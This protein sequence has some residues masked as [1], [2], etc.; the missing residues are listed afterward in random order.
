[1]IACLAVP[2]FAAAVERRGQTALAQTPLVI[3]GQPWEAAPLF[4]FSLEAAHQGVR[5]GMPL[6]QAHLLSPEA[7]FL[8]SAPLHYA[9]AD[10]EVTGVLADF[11]HLIAPEALWQ[12]APGV[13]FLPAGARSLPARYT[14]D[15]EALP[16]PEAVF[17]IR[18]MGQAVRDHTR[19]EP[20][21]GLSADP[22][23]AQVAAALARPGSLRPV[24]PGGERAFLAARPLDFLPLERE[25]LRRLRLLGIRTL[26]Q[27]AALSPAALRE[28][29]GTGI[30]PLHRL[31]RGEGAASVAS[32]PPSAQEQAARRFDPPLVNWLD[33]QRLLAEL[34]A[35][36]AGRLAA[37]ALLGGVLHLRVET[38]EDAPQQLSLPLRRPSADPARLAQAA[39][40][41]AQALSLESG[42]EALSLVAGDLRPAVV[43]QLSLFTHGDGQ[44]LAMS[45]AQPEEDESLAQL[46]AR[47]PAAQFLQPVHLDAAHPLAGRRFDLR[48]L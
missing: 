31:A 26:G 17:L 25:W 11:T 40:E 30:L 36:L 1:M 35:E 32:L 12:P 20:A 9:D 48:P 45:A 15:L 6:R 18:E 5:A 29:F 44:S 43:R 46:M 28:Q 23:A 34:A 3:G 27:F 4:G 24:E 21:A 37:A 19:L 33:V 42:V 41:L 13:R 2:Y 16:A 7:R 8:P 14:L 38:E 22:F 10:G 39:Q 47:H